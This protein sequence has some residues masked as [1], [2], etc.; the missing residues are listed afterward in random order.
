MRGRSCSADTRRGAIPKGRFLRLGAGRIY[1]LAKFSVN[2]FGNVGEY[3]GNDGDITIFLMISN[4]MY[5][6]N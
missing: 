3:H 2:S 6:V 5:L 1:L 4:L